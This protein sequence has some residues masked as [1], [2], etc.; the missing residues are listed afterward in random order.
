MIIAKLK[1]NTA[2]LEDNK[3]WFVSREGLLQYIQALISHAMQG[4]DRIEIP[5][6]YYDRKSLP[7]YSQLKNL[8]STALTE[9]Q[10][11]SGSM[12]AAELSAIYKFLNSGL[13][14]FN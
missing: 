1:L 11:K 5:E 14:G 8:L 12:S 4:A 7:D 2:G 6:F 10:R 3:P 13:R 9:L